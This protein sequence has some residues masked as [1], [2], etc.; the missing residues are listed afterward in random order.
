MEG[1][2]ANCYLCLFYYWHEG[3]GKEEMFQLARNGVE[4]IF[5]DADVKHDLTEIFNSA[6][7]N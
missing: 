1:N 2:V 4:F 3:L 7:K 5:A 6:A